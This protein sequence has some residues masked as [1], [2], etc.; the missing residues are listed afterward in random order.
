MRNPQD[1]LERIW[2]ILEDLYG[3]PRG[4]LDNAIRDVKWERGSLAS[5]VSS[6]QSYCTKLRNLKSVAISIGLEEERSRPKLVFRIVDCFNPVLYAQ[7]T[8]ENREWKR[9]QFHKVLSF[10]DEQISNLQ[11]KGAT[12]TTSQQ[13]LAKKR[14]KTTTSVSILSG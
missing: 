13:L 12:P 11:F 9:W 4:L 1:A 8:N 7:F 5:K 6:L 10:L 2:E 14:R 3:N